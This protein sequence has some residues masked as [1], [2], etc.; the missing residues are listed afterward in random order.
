MGGA[1]VKDAPPKPPTPL[2]REYWIR[3]GR[4]AAGAIVSSH[5]IKYPYSFFALAG[6]L[7]DE[8]LK[9]RLLDRIYYLSPVS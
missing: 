3:Q 4:R 7:R 9:R 8:D 5:L 1:K 6:E 2:A